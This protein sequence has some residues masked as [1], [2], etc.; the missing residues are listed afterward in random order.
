MYNAQDLADITNAKI[1]ASLQDNLTLLREV[2]RAP[3]NKD[4]IVREFRIGGERAAL[5]YIDGLANRETL[6]RHVLEPC[7]RMDRSDLPDKLS[8][9][10]DYLKERVISI[11]DVKSTE[12]IDECVQSVLFGKALLLLDGSDSGV[13]LEARSVFRRG[14]EKAINETVVLGPQ[15]GFVENLR[16]NL[17]LLRSGMRS[18]R[19]VTEML[20]LG[21]GIPTNCAVMYLDGVAEDKIVQEVLRR[22]R[23]VQIDHVADAGQL[24]QLIEDHPYAILPQIC[25]TE[26][27]DRACSFLLEGQVLVLVDGS[28]LALAMPISIL[29][30]SHTPDDTFMRWQAG[31]FLRTIRLI[32]MYVGVWLPA[33][34]IA[35]VIHHQ[36]AI[37][38]V[39]LSSVYDAQA[40]MPLPIA[41][42]ALTLLSAFHLINEASVRVPGSMGSSLGVVSALILGQAAVTADLVSPLMLIMIAVA[43]VGTFAVPDYTLNTSIKVRQVVFL[44]V[45]NYFGLYGVLL[46][47]LVYSN[48]LCMMTSMG[49]PFMA[50]LAPLRPHNADLRGR[51]PIW[52]QRSR[53]AFVNPRFAWRAQGRIRA[54]EQEKGDKL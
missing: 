19:L 41:I 52:M 44:L 30:L 51:M 32:G 1:V 22:I 6:E 53:G 2:L 28:P 14:V 4:C 12:E 24:E 25:S 29:H 35:L 23:G 20:S 31:T 15:E 3:R 27:P 39:L 5:V 50:P 17:A 48:E 33:V 46:L 11:Y 54:W 47:Y 45:S 26:R 16:T 13:L 36:H 8:E 40:R 10:I 34:Y 42:E 43:G 9:R 21:T 38:T 49:A 37:P 7:M 18:P